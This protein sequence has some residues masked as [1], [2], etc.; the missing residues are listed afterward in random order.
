MTKIF[1]I[2]GFKNSGKTT[3]T[4]RLI[5]EFKARG[6]VVSSIKHAH[7]EFDI[8]QLGTDSHQHR[9]AG[10][11]QVIISSAKRWALMSENA[12]NTEEPNLSELVS[13]LAPCDLVLVEGFKKENHPKILLITNGADKPL[14]DNFT[15][16]IA[17]ASEPSLDFTNDTLAHFDRDD[18][19]SI[20]DFIAANAVSAQ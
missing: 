7:H 6:L 16:V 18:I 4:A 9:S 8:D 13:H 19:G 11:T 10:A 5:K 20:A 15:N 12:P 1:G 3:L 17:I 2:S 14:L